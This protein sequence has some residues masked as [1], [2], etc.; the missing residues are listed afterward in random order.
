MVDIN[1]STAELELIK[2]VL[3][4]QKADELTS[5]ILEKVDSAT[6]R[7]KR[8]DVIMP[9]K[10]ELLIKRKEQGLTR[11]E[12]AEYDRLEEEIEQ[13]CMS[14]GYGTPHDWVWES[15]QVAMHNLYKQAQSH[16]LTPEEIAERNATAERILKEVLE[17]KTET[18][19]DFKRDLKKL[20]RDYKASIGFGADDDS[21]WYG[22]HGEHLYLN[23]NGK[24][25]ILCKQMNL[26]Q[27]DL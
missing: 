16:K 14:G 27:Y 22:I 8:L 10:H 12:S 9:R 4:K 23:M 13:A 5:G 2:E 1:F 18:P 24:K 25:T 6:P 3:S 21:D 17:H 26:N 15:Y 19:N 20:L 11:E 7:C